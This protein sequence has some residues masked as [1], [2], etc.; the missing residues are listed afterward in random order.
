MPIADWVDLM[1]SSVVVAPRTGVD[2]AGKPTFGA[3]VSY[4]ARIEMRNV[5]S[6]DAQGREIVG[7][8]IVFLATTTIPGSNSKITLPAGY[9]PLV[10][11]LLEVRPVPD[12]FGTHH[13]EIVIG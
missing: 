8:G 5:R 4:K 10:P 1:P 2:A 6:R 3:G 11:V 13:I 12:E 7:R 9:D